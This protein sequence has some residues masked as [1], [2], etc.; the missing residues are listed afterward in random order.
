MLVYLTVPE[1]VLV[2]VF[3]F[4]LHLC[5]LVYLTVPEPVHVSVFNCA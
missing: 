1:P 3:N 5:M 4:V 2:R